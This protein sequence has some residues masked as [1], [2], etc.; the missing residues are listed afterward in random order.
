MKCRL[1]VTNDRAVGA[2]ICAASVFRS[3]NEGPALRRDAP[4][5]GWLSEEELR[6][7]SQKMME[8]VALEKWTDGVIFAVRALSAL[9]AL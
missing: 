8:A 1:A 9:G 5:G 3:Y 6:E 7:T 2:S 4:G